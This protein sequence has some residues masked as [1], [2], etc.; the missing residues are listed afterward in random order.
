VEQRHRVN[1]LKTFF[2]TW[3]SSCFQNLNSTFRI[4]TSNYQSHYT[5]DSLR[6][7]HGILEE[8]YQQ[9]VASLEHMGDLNSDIVELQFQVTQKNM[10]IVSYL[11]YYE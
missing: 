5:T 10:E 7:E 9:Q 11:Q 3:Y 4:L 8:K 2:K 6:T 1:T